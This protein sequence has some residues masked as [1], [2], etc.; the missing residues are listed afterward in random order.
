[1]NYCDNSWYLRKCR[2]HCGNKKS[3]G[4]KQWC[5]NIEKAGKDSQFSLSFIW[6]YSYIEG[7]TKANGNLKA[8]IE[9]VVIAVS[10]YKVW[11]TEKF[12][13]YADDDYAM[14][15]GAALINDVRSVLKDP[16]IIYLYNKYMPSAKLKPRKSIDFNRMYRFCWWKN[17]FYR[18]FLCCCGWIFCLLYYLGSVFM[19]GV[20]EL[21][22]RFQKAED[23]AKR[24]KI[25]RKMGEMIF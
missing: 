6:D 5:F 1:M 9:G 14:N 4:A 2:D 11:R 8:F 17:F 25:T 19:D 23:E 16:I 15:H 13:L 18:L 20:G 21:G 10:D 12:R 22:I 24:K 7:Y 3:F